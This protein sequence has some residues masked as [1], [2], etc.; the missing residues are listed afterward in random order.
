MIPEQS[1]IS[2]TSVERFCFVLFCGWFDENVKAK[3]GHCI[4]TIICFY[5]TATFYGID[6]KNI[7]ICV[8]MS[9][10]SGLLLDFLSL[11]SHVEKNPKCY[12]VAF[13]PP[14]ADWM[15]SLFFMERFI[16]SLRLY[17]TV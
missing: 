7:N 17:W 5:S 6:F 12:Y 4:D 9:S 11:Y 16:F 2:T 10:D 13:R 3:L 14:S 1:L 8:K 15:V